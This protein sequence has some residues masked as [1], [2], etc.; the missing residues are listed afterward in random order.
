MNKSNQKKI[1]DKIIH[2]SETTPFSIDDILGILDRII[3]MASTGL[4]DVK[5]VLNHL[6]KRDH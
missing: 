2:L 1:I 6:K 3:S 5:K 4:I